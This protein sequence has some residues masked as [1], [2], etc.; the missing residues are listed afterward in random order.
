[1]DQLQTAV[2]F[3]T[4]PN[5]RPNFPWR[6]GTLQVFAAATI[7]TAGRGQGEVRN[8]PLECPG[9]PTC[10]GCPGLHSRVGGH[11]HPALTGH[12]PPQGGGTLTRPL[13][14]TLPL[15]GEVFRYRRDVFW[16][17]GRARK[18]GFGALL[19]PLGAVHNTRWV[20]LLRSLGGGTVVVWG[21]RSVPVRAYPRG[22]GAV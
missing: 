7:V 16:C 22:Y 5:L 13:R 8:V 4:V 21:V 11:P 1:M 15:K 6:A 20:W 18:R 9:C 14:A 12:P 10:P 17:A 2:P 19:R 3:V